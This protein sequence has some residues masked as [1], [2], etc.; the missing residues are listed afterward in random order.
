MLSMAGHTMNK[1]RDKEKNKNEYQA[2]S[3]GTLK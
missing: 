1:N 2:L 3:Q